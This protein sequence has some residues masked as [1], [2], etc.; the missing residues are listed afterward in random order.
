[1]ELHFRAGLK[2]REHAWKQNNLYLNALLFLTEGKA[3]SRRLGLLPRRAIPFLTRPAVIDFMD[4][5]RTV[6]RIVIASKVLL[7]RTRARIGT[8]VKS[9]IKNPADAYNLPRYLKRKFT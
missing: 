8:V 9:L 1:V 5:Q 7:L 3:T 4:R 6:C 2:Y